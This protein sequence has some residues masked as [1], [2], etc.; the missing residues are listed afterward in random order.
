VAGFL[1]LPT[2]VENDRLTCAYYPFREGP[3]TDFELYEGPDG[4]AA[5]VPHQRRGADLGV[6][7]AGPVR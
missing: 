2:T 5:A 1:D 6:L 3:E 4:W 7:P